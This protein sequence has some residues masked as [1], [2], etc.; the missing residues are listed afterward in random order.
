MGIALHHEFDEIHCDPLEE[1]RVVK[2]RGP[3]GVEIEA[4]S[5]YDQ[6]V[7][8]TGTSDGQIQMFRR[9]TKAWACQWSG[10][11]RT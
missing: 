4:L 2:T 1:A 8:V 6:R 3:S 9:G 10:P 7:S 5:D 11:S